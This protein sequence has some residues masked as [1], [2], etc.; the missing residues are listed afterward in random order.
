VFLFFVKKFDYGLWTKEVALIKA[1]GRDIKIGM[2]AVYPH[3][4]RKTLF[5]VRRKR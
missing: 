5:F 3:G 2:I 4:S 1:Y